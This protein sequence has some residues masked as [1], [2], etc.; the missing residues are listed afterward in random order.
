MSVKDM[1]KFMSAAAMSNKEIQ[2]FLWQEGF[3]QFYG[4]I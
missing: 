3:E 4:S 1:Q 2:E